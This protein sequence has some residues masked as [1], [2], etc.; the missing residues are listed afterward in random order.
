MTPRQ[1]RGPVV[2]GSLGGA[3]PA[4]YTV[5]AVNAMVRHVLDSGIGPLWV[6]GEVTGWKR[7]T[8]GHCY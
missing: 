6:Q 7:H 1:D 2:G 8:S 3:R 5:A 4:A